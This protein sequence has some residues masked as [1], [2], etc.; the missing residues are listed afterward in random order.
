MGN[1][2]EGFQQKYNR[3]FTKDDLNDK[4]KFDLK[5]FHNSMRGFKGGAED[6]D[7]IDKSVQVVSNND[8]ATL[9]NT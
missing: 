6:F 9:K 4:S 7:V 5:E 2:N 3:E 1:Y 8:N